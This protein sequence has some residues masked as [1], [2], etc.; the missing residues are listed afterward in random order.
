MRKKFNILLGDELFESEC[1]KQ[2]E[3]DLIRLVFNETEKHPVK[4]VLHRIRMDM[5]SDAEKNMIL[6]I[7]DID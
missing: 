4:N 5:L 1:Y 6:K 2:S 7:D 3:L